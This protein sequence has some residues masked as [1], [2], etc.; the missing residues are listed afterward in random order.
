[1]LKLPSSPLVAETPEA[2]SRTLAPATPA[3]STTRPARASPGSSISTWTSSRS[4]RTIPTASVV[5]PCPE[6][7]ATCQGPARRAEVANAPPGETA[8]STC[9]R[10]ALTDHS[11][12]PRRR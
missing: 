1:M 4:A 8:T 7:K 11:R 5:H 10:P 3:P 2:G 12:G 6:A 9:G